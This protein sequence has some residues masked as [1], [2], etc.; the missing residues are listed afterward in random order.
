MS[1]TSVF[2]LGSTAIMLLASACGHP[3]E[4]RLEGRWRGDSV[5][6][7][8][9]EE[10]AAATGW[11]RAT[12]FD[13]HDKK[14]TVAIPAEDPRTGTFEIASF[15]D[16]RVALAVTRP[17]GTRDR[18]DLILDD[19]RSMRWVLDRERTITMQRLD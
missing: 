4:R 14:L 2:A 3:A 7:F 1:R 13:F 16:G 5:Q 15:R 9:I 10:L 6:K 11:A 19:E 12:T 17:D 18:L 8:A